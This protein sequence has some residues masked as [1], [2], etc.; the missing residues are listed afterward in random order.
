MGDED[1]RDGLKQAADE[2]RWI[3]S[4]RHTQSPLEVFLTAPPQQE[5]E[6][7]LGFPLD[8]EALQV[9][10][11]RNAAEADKGSEKT[12]AATASGESMPSKPS[13]GSRPMEAS[14]ALEP[15]AA[16]ESKATS[17]E[18]AND[19]A[20]MQEPLQAP[21][22]P[23][24]EVPEAPEVESHGPTKGDKLATPPKASH[25]PVIEV[26]ESPLK[27]GPDAHLNLN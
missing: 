2:P 14:E 25:N 20:T 1:I 13:S 6:R 7:I 5:L 12:E 21:D 26:M 4:D 16:E 19:A 11:Q 10:L 17:T 18:L 3:F 22:V 15:D 23:E 24:F 8:P 27:R 9:W